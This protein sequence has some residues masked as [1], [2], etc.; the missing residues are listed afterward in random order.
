MPQRPRIAP[1][2][3]T[4]RIECVEENAA[5]TQLALPADELADLDELA[6][7]IGGQ[8]NRYN[9]MHMGLVRK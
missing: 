4:R 3:G 2:P 9:E 7:R 6:V 8:G 1:L 5:S